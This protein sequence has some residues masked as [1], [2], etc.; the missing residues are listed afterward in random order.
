MAARECVLIQTGHSGY[1][2]SKSKQRDTQAN[3]FL[4]AKMARMRNRLIWLYSQGTRPMDDQTG[5][6]HCLGFHCPE[7]TQHEPTVNTCYRPS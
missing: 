7:N 1:R 6:C 3:I 2:G 4:M 5:Q